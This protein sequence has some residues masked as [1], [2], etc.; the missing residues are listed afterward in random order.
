[1]KKI[2]LLTSC[3][4]LMSLSLALF[5]LSSPTSNA[6]PEAS[7]KF[8]KLLKGKLVGLNGKRVSRRELSGDPEYYAFYFSAHWCPPCRT[9]TPKLVDFYNSNAAAGKKFE[10]IFVSSDTSEDK[11]ED[12]IKEDKMP[13]PAIKYRYAKKIKEISK[14]AGSGIPCLVLVDREGKVISDSYNGENY[15][16]PTKVMRDIASTVK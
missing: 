2:N 6:A 11:M 10:I 5:L 16:G 1:M 8:Q 3:T 14:Y 4:L 13:W 15:I 12:Y 9:F 7:S